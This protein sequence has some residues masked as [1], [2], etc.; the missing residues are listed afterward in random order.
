MQKIKYNKYAILRRSLCNVFPKNNEHDYI[1]LSEIMR[2]KS[3]I[4]DQFI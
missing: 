3:P 1:M 2:E 4:S